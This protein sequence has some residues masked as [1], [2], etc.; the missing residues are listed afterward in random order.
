MVSPVNA[1]KVLGPF[2]LDAVVVVIV[3]VER[4]AGL[5]RADVV[6]VGC[7]AGAGVEVVFAGREGGRHGKSAGA[8]CEEDK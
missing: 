2:Y 6:V 3:K 8:Q 1:N 5:L 7:D 4:C